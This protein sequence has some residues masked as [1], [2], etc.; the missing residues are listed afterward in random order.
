MAASESSE[1]GH[2]GEL[3]CPGDRRLDSLRGRVPGCG[4]ADNRSAAD[5][6]TSAYGF[7]DARGKGTDARGKGTDARGKGTDAR[8]K[9]RKIARSERG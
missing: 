4:R 9:G 8:G 7:T 6:A 5:R 3:L 1:A 2:D